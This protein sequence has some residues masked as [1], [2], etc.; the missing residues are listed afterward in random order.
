MAEKLPDKP[1][2]YDPQTEGNYSWWFNIHSQQWIATL[3]TKP[4]VPPRTVV[5]ISQYFE[6]VLGGSE[7]IIRLRRKI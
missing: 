4:E 3:K 1:D 7:P 6:V 2:P 5:R